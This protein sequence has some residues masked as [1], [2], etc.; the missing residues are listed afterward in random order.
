MIHEAYEPFARQIWFSLVVVSAAAMDA[1]F[2]AHYP[3]AGPIVLRWIVVGVA[4]SVASVT[5]TWVVWLK[6]EKRSLLLRL[7]PLA[8]TF[9]SRANAT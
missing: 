6:G 3:I 5:T 2:I 1:G 4:T 7:Q 8:A 9:V